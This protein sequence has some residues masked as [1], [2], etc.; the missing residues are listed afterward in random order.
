MSRTLT[1]RVRE[2]LE[3]QGPTR[4][5]DLMRTLG[6]DVGS[7]VNR[8]SF[9]KAISNISGIKRDGDLYSLGTTWSVG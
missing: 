1:E 4:S 6:I 8:I 5:V 9:I 7:Q 3:N 2:L